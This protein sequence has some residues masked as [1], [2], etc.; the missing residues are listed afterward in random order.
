M[1]VCVMF[2][3]RRHTQA[4][5]IY[6]MH[7]SLL[8]DLCSYGIIV[9]LSCGDSLFIQTKSEQAALGFAMQ[10]QSLKSND[11]LCGQNHPDIFWVA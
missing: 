2:V 5:I 1:T 8:L 11:H 9:C 3:Y 6:P 7:G 10:M 4:V